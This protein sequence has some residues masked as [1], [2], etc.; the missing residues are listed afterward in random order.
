MFEV[1]TRKWWVVALRGV[2]AILFGIVAFVYPGATVL[3]LVL[4]FGAYALVDGVFAIFA[5]FGSGGRDTAWHILEGIGGIAVGIVTFLYPGISAQ[6]LIYLI[7]FYAILTGVFEVVAGFELPIA[8][9][10]LLV[11]AG[12]ASVLFGVL[13]FFNP[14]SGAIAIVWLIGGYAL[15]FGVMMV[16]FGIRLRNIGTMIAPQTA[17]T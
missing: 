13:I 9:A 6:A 1:L 11:L 2:L 8:K 14:Q 16:V 15:I 7:G 3:S 4:I 17:K 5:A 10:W 12:A